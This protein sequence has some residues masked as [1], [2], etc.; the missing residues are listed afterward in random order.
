MLFKLEHSAVRPVGTFF[1]SFALSLDPEGADVGTVPLVVGRG[2]GKLGQHGADG[3]GLAHLTYGGG[4][5]CLGDLD[6]VGA[7]G[8]R[9]E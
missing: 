4:T 3:L 8:I 9:C 2:A 1:A 7:V 6:T 5:V